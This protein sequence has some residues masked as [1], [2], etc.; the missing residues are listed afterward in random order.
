MY[1]VLQAVMLQPGFH[2]INIH[3]SIL[4]QHLKCKNIVHHSTTISMGVI[5]MCPHIQ[6]YLKSREQCQHNYT[7]DVFQLQ[8]SILLICLAWGKRTCQFFKWNRHIASLATPPAHELHQPLSLFV[9]CTIF[10]AHY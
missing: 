1:S 3:S 7:R 9:Y 10:I 4:E 2:I 5:L 8:Y 6:I